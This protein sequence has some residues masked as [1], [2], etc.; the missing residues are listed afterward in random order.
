MNKIPTGLD[1]IGT[2]TVLANVRAIAPDGAMVK[3]TDDRIPT[4][5]RNMWVPA[6]AFAPEVW[7]AMHQT[8]EKGENWLGESGTVKVNLTIIARVESVEEH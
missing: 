2:I 6:S 4:W 8:D 5:R 3:M 7:E 1:H